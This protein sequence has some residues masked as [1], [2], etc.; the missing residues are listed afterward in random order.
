MLG[1]TLLWWVLLGGE[2]EIYGGFKGALGIHL[3]TLGAPSATIGAVPMGLHIAYDRLG[4]RQQTITFFSLLLILW[5]F[6][7]KLEPI[8]GSRLIYVW[9]EMGR[10]DE[11]FARSWM[12][13]I[14]ALAS[15][16]VLLMAV[17]GCFYLGRLGLSRRLW[18]N[19]LLCFVMALMGTF[20]IDVHSMVP[21]VPVLALA[22]GS[23][24]DREIQGRILWLGVILG[25]ILAAFHRDAF[26]SP[27]LETVEPW[28]LGQGVPGWLGYFPQI[29]VWVRCCFWFFV[30]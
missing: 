5:W 24:L 16:P 21:L 1:V 8:T 29:L 6:L 18:L 27:V 26:Q 20:I 28:W 25:S 9:T 13:L 23:F 14:V 11:Q 17:P 2:G 7:W 30:L 10:L 15:D 3:V 12:N 4:Y 19:L 22:V